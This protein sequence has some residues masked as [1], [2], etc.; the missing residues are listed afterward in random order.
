MT[1]ELDL[2]EGD[3]EP[4]LAEDFPQLALLQ[5]TVE[6]RPG[7]SPAEVRER[8]RALADRYTGAK[9]VH[10]RQSPV[11]WAYRVFSRQVGI[12]PDSDR[13]PAEAIAVERLRHGGFK[14]LGLVEDALTIAVAETGVP[15]LALDP[16]RLE[17]P[18]S[19]RLARSG[20]WLGP[21]RPLSERQI[22]VADEA[23][24]VAL[25]LGEVAPDAAPS[26][27]TAQVLLA[28]LEVK[29]VPRIAVEEALWTAAEILFQPGEAH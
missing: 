21:S 19:L 26:A 22:V 20:E 15:V 23:R 13:P 6:A 9:V 7:R 29:G 2:V 4:R 27:A 28:A 25:V 5:A 1:L 8:L 3:V 17:G 11:P 24:P 14:S 18:L 10:M 16:E 12:D